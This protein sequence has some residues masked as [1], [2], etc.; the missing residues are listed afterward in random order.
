MMVLEN[1]EVSTLAEL[2]A[3]GVEMIEVTTLAELAI[4]CIRSYR[5]QEGRH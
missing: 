1:T 3:V 5:N 2:A 4:V